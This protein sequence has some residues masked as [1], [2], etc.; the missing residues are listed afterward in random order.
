MQVKNKQKTNKQTDKKNP[1]IFNFRFH[2]HLVP[3]EP[4]ILLRH[5]TNKTII[6]KV[7]KI[8]IN[9]AEAICEKINIFV[10]R[11]HII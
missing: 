5:L 9:L 6:I 3:R 7:H 10:M 2:D 4:M 1:N 11:L 8:A